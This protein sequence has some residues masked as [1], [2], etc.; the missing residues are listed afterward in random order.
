MRGSSFRP[1]L[2]ARHVVKCTTFHAVRR[3]KE[4]AGMAGPPGPSWSTGVSVQDDGGFQL[5][6]DSGASVQ[7]S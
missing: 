7:V 3:V 5:L 4:S 2:A 1:L 6:G